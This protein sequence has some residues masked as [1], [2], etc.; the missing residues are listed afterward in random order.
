MREIMT[1]LACL[2]DR[3]A[4]GHPRQARRRAGAGA[5]DG[6]D[7]ARV[8]V[9]KPTRTRRWSGVRDAESGPLGPQ[10]NSFDVSNLLRVGLVLVMSDNAAAELDE[11]VVREIIL[12][13][14]RPPTA[15]DEVIST[16]SSW[17]VVDSRQQCHGCF[18][19]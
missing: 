7:I 10:A 9:A 16:V 4:R 18:V 1:V 11:F 15:D 13:V 19:S 12:R 5:G 3:R 6:E 14:I 17:H 8:S 2:E